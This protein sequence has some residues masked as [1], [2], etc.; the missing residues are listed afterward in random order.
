MLLSA[1]SPGR[2]S[3]IIRML[4][5]E[6]PR[7]SYLSTSRSQHQQQM[8]V[9]LYKGFTAASKN[10]ER[11]GS[12][13]EQFVIRRDIA[14]KSATIR[15]KLN[16]RNGFFFFFFNLRATTFSINKGSILNVHQPGIKAVTSPTRRVE[17]SRRLWREVENVATCSLQSQACAQTMHL[18]Y[19]K[20]FKINVF[21]LMCNSP[22]PTN[23][24]LPTFTTLEMRCICFNTPQIISKGTKHVG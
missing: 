2:T 6:I 9:K 3:V 7:E 10:P 23:S 18:P 4:R 15:A 13:Q 14:E 11:R 1:L 20:G 17:L 19:K 12:K 21:H 5:C 22:V 24:T 16:R 8:M